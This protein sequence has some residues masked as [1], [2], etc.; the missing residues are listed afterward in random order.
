[1]VL[2]VVLNRPPPSE[3]T[4]QSVDRMDRMDRMDCIDRGSWIVDRILVRPE[5][6]L[7][8]KTAHISFVALTQLNNPELTVFQSSLK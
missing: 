6:M 2:K 4:L 3:M 1:M 5:D 7:I 8:L